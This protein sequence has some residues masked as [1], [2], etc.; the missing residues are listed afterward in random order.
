M[1]NQVKGLLQTIMKVSKRKRLLPCFSS[2]RQET[3]L[4]PPRSDPVRGTAERG[5]RGGGGAGPGAAPRA[6]AGAPSYASSARPSRPVRG[7]GEAA[8]VCSVSALCLRLCGPRGRKCLRRGAAHPLETL[9]CAP[10]ARAPASRA[11]RVPSSTLSPRAPGRRLSSP[12]GSV[13]AAPGDLQAPAGQELALPFPSR[14]GADH[15]LQRE[16]R[17][18]ASAER[19]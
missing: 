10:N 4:L 5:G 11:A 3:R 17:G 8:A 7:P 16:G 15:P 2:K 14:E 19:T 1:Q 18:E 6:A 12:G 13:L 9:P